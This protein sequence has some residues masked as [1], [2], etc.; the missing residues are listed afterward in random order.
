MV[1]YFDLII[2]TWSKDGK[3]QTNVSKLNMYKKDPKI[4]VRFV[5]IH[6][7][8]NLTISFQYSVALPDGRIQIV[9]YYADDSGYHA[10]V[11]YEGVAA[12]HPVPLPLHPSPAPY[13]PT[14]SPAPYKPHPAPYKPLPAPTPYK[15]LKFPHPAP[16]PVKPV[17]IV[18]PQLPA[19][20]QTRILKDPKI[21]GHPLPEAVPAVP[22]PEA[23]EEAPEPAPIVTP[24]P[25]PAAPPPSPIHRGLPR[26]HHG[27][28]PHG[29]YPRALPHIRDH[30]PLPKA[31]LPTPTPHYLPKPTPYHYKKRKH[32]TPSPYAPT[33][34]PHQ[35]PTPT[36]KWVPL[37]SIH[38]KPAVYKP[39]P[40]PYAAKVGSYIG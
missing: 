4:G 5:N 30:A 33:V 22:E 6:T 12:A 8:L 40:D 1:D 17:G 20:A 21:I 19:P 23:T 27:P 32:Y 34:V 31:Y 15:P 26:V 3:Y 10:D 25:A 11:K 28:A 9:T 29:G 18:P 14:L 16:L 13:K 7:L 39:K 36:P 35:R 2:L 38:L 24:V 37:K